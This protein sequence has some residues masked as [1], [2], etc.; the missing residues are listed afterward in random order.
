MHVSKCSH[1]TR[2]PTT[3]F[4]NRYVGG[5][6][7]FVIPTYSDHF[8]AHTFSPFPFN[9]S[10]LWN[11]FVLDR[12]NLVPQPVACIANHTSSICVFDCLATQLDF[13]AC[14]CCLSAKLCTYSTMAHLFFFAKLHSAVQPCPMSGSLSATAWFGVDANIDHVSHQCHFFGWPFFTT[15]QGAVAKFHVVLTHALSSLPCP[16]SQRFVLYLF[17]HGHVF[18]IFTMPSGR[19]VGA[20][21]AL[22]F[23]RL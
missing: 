21:Q 9:A 11:M 19:N 7:S 15:T 18:R 16:A 4:Q 14:I 3:T 23:F 8:S 2:C 13:V 10:S 20:S 6:F 1:Q 5:Q 17:S 12:P 22:Y